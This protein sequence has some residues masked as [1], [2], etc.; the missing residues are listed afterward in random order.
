MAKKNVVFLTG[1]IN[2][3][4]NDNKTLFTVQIRKNEK[5]FV[6]PIVQLG[7]EALEVRSELKVG[8]LIC[9]QGRIQTEQKEVTFNCP[10]CGEEMINKYTLTTVYADVAK[11]MTPISDEPFINTVILLGAV[12]R[13][14]E[15]KYINGTI[16]PVANTKYQIAV[17]RREKDKAD[18]PWISTFAKQ[19]EE[20]ARRLNVSSQVLVH[21]SII[22]RQNNKD[23]I[24]PKCECVV[25]ISE[26]HTEILGKTV[27]YL[28]NCVF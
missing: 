23:C 11:L 25:P 17:N 4:L 16:S 6:Y 28:N 20:D 24:C 8:D 1:F 19:A 15:F 2:E 13:D 3:I 10:D 27:E 7:E 12:C 22:T 21:G 18:F 5:K 9:I 14:K 26:M